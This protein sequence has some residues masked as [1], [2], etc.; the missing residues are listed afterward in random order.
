MDSM[1]RRRETPRKR[2]ERGI[3]NTGREELQKPR[4]E[5]VKKDKVINSANDPG[6]P[7][8]RFQAGLPWVLGPVCGIPKFSRNLMARIFNGRPAQKGTTP[9][10]AMLS[11]LNGQ[12]FCGGSLLGSKWIVTVA[13]CLH[14]LL[15]SEEAT[16]HGLDLLSPSAFKI[17]MGKHWRYR[18][19]ENEQ[20]LNVKQIFLH[21]LYNPNTFENDM[22][23]VELLKSPVLND[24]VMPI[25]LPQ[26]PSQE[27]A[28][29][30]VSGWGKQF[31][32]R[33]PETLM[34]I[35]IPVVDHRIC[36]EAYTPL[37]RKVTRDMICAGEKE[38]GKD[39][40]AGDS[41]GPMATLDTERGQWYLVGTVSWGV[42][43]GKKDRYGVYSYIFHNKD[44]IQR[45]TGMRN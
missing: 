15:D 45:V 18:S 27:G 9:W 22:A 3:R 35:E 4:R 30:I 34:E 25:C 38:G 13:H 7:R 10:I 20:S 42:D 1:E 44:W 39:A 2:Q 40:C 23:L 37:K 32:Q 29:V 41:G 16:L 6:Q 5:R 33:F 8:G 36:Q 24:F 43:C 11:H 14:Q 12:P 26:G 28:M 31:L 17:I 21:P 19:D